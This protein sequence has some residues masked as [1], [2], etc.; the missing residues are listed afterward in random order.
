M[1]LDVERQLQTP[2]HH[3]GGWTVT[4]NYLVTRTLLGFDVL[5]LADLI[6]AYKRVTQRRV[7]FIPVGKTFAAELKCLGGNASIQ[8]PEARIDK[9][10]QIVAA[11]APWA[12]FGYSDELIKM[13]NNNNAE[14]CAAVDARRYARRR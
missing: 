3:G 2:R 13:W 7:N 11:R 10:L 4:D 14:F 1:A 8:G 6:W 12:A 5:R 9:V